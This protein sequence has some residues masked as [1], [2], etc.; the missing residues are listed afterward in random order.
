MSNICNFI[1]FLT[2]DDVGTWLYLIF[3]VPRKLLCYLQLSILNNLYVFL[4]LIYYVAKDVYS[5]L[6]ECPYK[7]TSIV[8][9]VQIQ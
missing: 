7:L 4:V 3:C 6:N 2:R 1:Q 8:H 9:N 5:T